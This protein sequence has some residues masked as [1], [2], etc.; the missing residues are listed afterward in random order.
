MTV[1]TGLLVSD[2]D[3]VQKHPRGGRR[4]VIV[5]DD[6]VTVVDEDGG[7]ADDG[8]RAGADRVVD[9]FGDLVEL[10]GISSVT[11]S[12]LDAAIERRRRR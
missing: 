3:L 9:A 11:R 2:F 5:H 10:E 4:H 1:V 12:R 8:E 7:V 6:H